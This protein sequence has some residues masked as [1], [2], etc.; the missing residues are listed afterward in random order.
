MTQIEKTGRTVEEAVESA[1]NALGIPSDEADV[2]VLEEPRS[3]FLGMGSRDARV[4]VRVRSLTSPPT[5]AALTPGAIEPKA[6]RKKST[7]AAKAEVPTV[8]APEPVAA[9]KPVAARKPVA[10]PN[11]PAAKPTPYPKRDTEDRAELTAAQVSVIVEK[12]LDFL[13]KVT[14]A[15]DLP[16][17]FSYELQ[18]GEL[19]I[20]ATGTQLGR[21]IGHRGE[22]LDALQY[23]TVQASGCHGDLRLRLDAM[24]YRVRRE[25]VLVQLAGRAAD[26]VVATRQRVVMEAMTPAERRLIHTLLQEHAEVYTSS[27]GEEPRRRVVVLLKENQ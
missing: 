15:M 3:G 27:E 12:A 24:Q 13:T 16:A 8:D 11:A 4:V 25:Q 14:Q 5:V 17:Q 21:M 26:T 9:A 22:T 23:L 10:L 20:N 18:S 7:R 2:E 1:L 19:L 6:S